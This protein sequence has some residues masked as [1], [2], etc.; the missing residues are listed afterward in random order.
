M[1]TTCKHFFLFSRDINTIYLFT[2]LIN[3]YK[4]FIVE[5]ELQLRENHASIVQ[6]WPQGPRSPPALGGVRTMFCLTAAEVRRGGFR[7]EDRWRELQRYFG[8]QVYQIQ[9]KVT[10]FESPPLCVFVFIFG[11]DEHESDGASCHLPLR[12]NHD[13]INHII[14]FIKC[15]STRADVGI[16]FFGILKKMTCYGNRRSSWPAV[17]QV[18]STDS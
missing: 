2:K 6:M 18:K 14:L 15:T 16:R 8:T 10:V 5:H 17:G 12:T 13:F 3:I 11:Q 9:D 4:S 7:A 1:S